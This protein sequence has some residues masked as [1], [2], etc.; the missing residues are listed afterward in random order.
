MIF[1]QTRFVPLARLSMVD[2]GEHITQQIFLSVGNVQQRRQSEKLEK[3][4]LSFPKRFSSPAKLQTR[5]GRSPDV[6]NNVGRKTICNLFFSHF[7]YLLKFV[8]RV[9]FVENERRSKSTAPSNSI[10][11]SLH[12]FSLSM[13][14]PRKT[15]FRIYDSIKK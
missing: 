13:I 7:I 15:R 5:E 12:Q 8:L 2:S 14:F 9:L 1:K 10:Y 3:L 11:L 4:L 6:I